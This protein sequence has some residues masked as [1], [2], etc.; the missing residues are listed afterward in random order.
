M[1]KRF[2]LVL[3][4]DS[5]VDIGEINLEPKASPPSGTVV[6]GPVMRVPDKL[7]AN[8]PVLVVYHGE[9]GRIVKLQL[10][11]PSKFLVEHFQAREKAAEFPVYLSVDYA[12]DTARIAFRERRVEV[13]FDPRR[14]LGTISVREVPADAA[15]TLERGPIAIEYNSAGKLTA[16]SLADIRNQLPA[17]YL[18]SSLSGR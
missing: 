9:G 10:L 15:G 3:V 2:M 11:A 16:I 7:Q 13:A 8:L 4:V 14:N 5:S 17:C 12:A 18:P 1:T 6:Y